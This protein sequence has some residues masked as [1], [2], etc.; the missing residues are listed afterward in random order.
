MKFP[1]FGLRTPELE[2]IVKRLRA[3]WLEQVYYVLGLARNVDCKRWWRPAL[4]A[5][6][7]GKAKQQWEETQQPARV[8]AEFE[9]ETVSGSWNRRRRVVAKAEL[10][11]GQ[12]NPRFIVTAF[13]E[14]AWQAQPL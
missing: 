1:G 5:P 8:F 13:A 3:A 11:D 7:V 2:R 10:I 6:S 14:T 4:M 9:H 12:S